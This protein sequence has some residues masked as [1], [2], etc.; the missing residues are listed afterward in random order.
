MIKNVYTKATVTILK[1][2]VHTY[3]KETYHYQ[4]I[5]LEH[6]IKYKNETR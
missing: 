5:K 4:E 6:V 2:N 1:G 3:K